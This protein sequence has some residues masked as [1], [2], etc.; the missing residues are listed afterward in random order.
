MKTSN[1]EIADLLRSV[2]ASLTLSK[3]NAFQ[4]RAYEN[5]A[6]SIERLT[7]E[8]KDLWEEGKLGEVPGIGT[9]LKE[10]LNE[11]FKTGES[12]HLESILKKHPEVVYELI[13]VPGIG[14]K[15]ALELA[16]LG[17]KDID[18]LKKKIESG[19]LTKKGFSE[20]ISERV[21]GGLEEHAGKTGRMLLPYAQAQADRILEYLKKGPDVKDADPLG[22]LRRQVATIGDLDFAVS[23][24]NSEKV[25][26]YFVK[27]PGV[28]K[29]IDKETVILNSGIHVD[30]L[31][32]K[33]ESYGALL[34][35]FTG[36]KNHNIKLR[37]LALK[38]GL[39]LSED[40]VKKVGS[41]KLIEVK[42]EE[43]FYKLLGM[44]T[45]APEIREDVEEIEAA[46]EYKLP[47][48]IELKDIKG[49]LHLHSNFQ[50]EHP[51]HG[52]G[53]N[54]IEDIVKRAEELG[55][56]Y[57]GISDHPPA[58]GT[59]SKEGIIRWVEKRTKFIQNIQ[60]GNKSIRV[61]NGLEIDILSDGSL[62]VPDEALKTLDYCIA[63]IHHGHRGTP[64]Q[65]TK[66]ILKA[67]ENPY[68]DILA[69]PTGRLLNER[70]SYDADWEEIFKFAAKNERSSSSSKKLM[71]ING[72]PNRLDLRDDLV[73]LALKF[74]VKFVID[75]DAHEVDQ[76]DN[77][78]FGVSVARRGWVES[79]DVVNS[80][81]W[82]KFAEW[83]N[84][85]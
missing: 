53:A 78:R 82:K 71:E 24:N 4:V 36:S 60:K 72:Y 75:T 57:V 39:S 37:T 2:A 34:Q 19:E 32:G 29:V 3:A 26:E 9:G 30:L 73:R 62:S 17:V 54:P 44:D 45:P 42:S 83:F 84:I 58:Q 18:D 51:S 76:M 55:Y 80:W 59:E 63:G 79:K 22:S 43:E 38:K 31:V 35:H 41:G 77:M 68:V 69:H 40:G 28:S 14:P 65:I 61:L 7:S 85:H 56:E 15:T 5:A 10:H 67:L 6:D 52:P 33:P 48:L 66:R 13:K 23:A 74:G 70:G 1:Q 64:E 50:I 20:K 81:E 27:M 11:I 21:L 12:K 16:N 46:L 8:I 49:D 47:D 25:Y